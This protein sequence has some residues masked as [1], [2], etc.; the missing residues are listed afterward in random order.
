MDKKIIGIDVGGTKIAGGLVDK[1]GRLDKTVTL[2]TKAK[3]GFETSFGQVLTVIRRLI[4]QAG[5][6][7]QVKGIGICCPGP[8]NPRTGEVINP[9]N[10]PGWTNINFTERVEKEFQIPA[11]LE[12][13]ANAA[14]LAEVLFGAAVGHNDVFYVTVSTGVGTGIIIDKKIYHGKNGIAAEG[15]HVTIDHH[16]PYICGCGT[17]GCIEALAAGPAMARRARVK[18]E[19]HH[20]LPSLLRERTQNHLSRITPEMIE[21]TAADGDEV[22][23]FIIEETGFF[24]GVWLAAMITLLDPDAIVIGGGVSRIGKP[25]FDKIRKTIPHYTINRQAI[26]TPLLPAKLQKDVGIFGAASLFLQE[27]EG[28]EKA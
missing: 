20:T 25:L 17:P 11:R 12:N 7:D 6:A 22:A 9:P 13:D 28:T 18:L 24:L 27:G 8:L 4:N 23:K 5:G 19:Q 10:L 3:E 1:K 26:H 21:E 2:P 14:G 16:S 15:G